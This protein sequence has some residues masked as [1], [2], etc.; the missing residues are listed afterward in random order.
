MLPE[1]GFEDFQVVPSYEDY[2][3]RVRQ[4]IGDDSIDVKILDASKW[5]GYDYASEC[6]V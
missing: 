5:Y 4:F 2:K 1:P 3:S 6:D